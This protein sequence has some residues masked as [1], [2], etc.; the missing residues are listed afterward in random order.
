MSLEF[1]KGKYFSQEQK[2]LDLSVRRGKLQ[3]MPVSPYL[4]QTRTKVFFVF[5]FFSPFFFLTV[6]TYTALQTLL[7]EAIISIKIF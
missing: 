4:T 5:F 2:S 6:F 7:S 3:K 1:I